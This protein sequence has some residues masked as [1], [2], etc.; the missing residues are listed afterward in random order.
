MRRGKQPP[1]IA[2]LPDVKRI[3]FVGQTGEL[4]G[5]EFILLDVAEYFRATCHVAL[6]ADGPLRERLVSAGVS[7]SIIKT[8]PGLLKVARDA[9]SSAGLAAIPATFSTVLKV[10]RMASSFD[11]VYANSQKAALIAMLAARLARKPVTWHLHDIFSQK[12]Y[13]ALQRRAVVTVANAVASAVIANSC[14]SAEGFVKAGG[15]PKK[16]HVVPNGIDTQRFLSGLGNEAASS[17]SKTPEAR[18]LKIGLFGRLTHWKGQ[19]VLIKALSS[20]PDARAIIVGEALFGE[21]NYKAEL[22]KLALQIG[23]DKQISWLGFRSDVAALMES[24][25][26]VVHTSRAPE[27]FGRVLLEAMLA[28]RPIV[29]TAGGASAEVLGADYPFLV[30]PDDPQALAQALSAIA[31]MGTQQIFELTAKGFERATTL[32]SLSAMLE[33]IERVLAEA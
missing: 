23:V 26:V 33:G 29:A 9:P 21:Q 16:L 12:E 25:D 20:L 13:G 14:A 4:G 28:R 17:P 8:S 6:L 3:L 18:P 19:D 7:V 24:V 22:H 11:L 31:D 15:S 27:P 10:A 5:A 1:F 30:P 32:F 2:K